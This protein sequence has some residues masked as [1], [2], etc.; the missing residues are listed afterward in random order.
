[1]F[2]KDPQGNIVV[3]KNPE[4]E[5]IDKQ[6]NRVNKK[7]YLVDGEGNVIDRR[8]KIVF[9]ASQ[10]DSDDE[11]PGFYTVD[12]LEEYDTQAEGEDLEEYQVEKELKA[13]KSVG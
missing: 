1:M 7:G 4:G 8:G 11:I 5:L 2:D 6:G 10:L 12:E 9:K 13:I 3:M